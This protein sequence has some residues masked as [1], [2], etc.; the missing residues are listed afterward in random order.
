MRYS[1]AEGRSTMRGGSRSTCTTVAPSGT[2]WPATMACTSRFL[3]SVAARTASSAF[4]IMSACFGV[5]SRFRRAGSFF[6]DMGVPVR[7]GW[8]VILALVV[9]GACDSSPTE[10]AGECHVELR[11]RRQDPPRRGVVPVDTVRVCEPPHEGR[12]P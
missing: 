8:L 3:R 2:S 11:E 12:Y 10:P 4:T 5:T 1:D 9:I 7:K 6:F